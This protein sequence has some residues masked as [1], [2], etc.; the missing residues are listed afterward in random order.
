MTLD[1]SILAVA[2]MA[3]QAYSQG[4]FSVGGMLID[5]NGNLIKKMHNNVV[6]K[7]FI[8]DPTAH[9]ER[10]LIDWYFMEK[11]KSV[12]L[13]EPKD[14]ILITSLDPCCMCTA[15]ILLSGF[16]VVVAAYDEFA[17]IN[18]NKKNNFPSA[19]DQ[20]KKLL[21]KYFSYPKVDGDSIF[22]RNQSGASLPH[23]FQHQSIA[24]TSQALC[25]SI[26]NASA[27]NV[28]YHENHDLQPCYLKNPRDLPDTHPIILELKKYYPQTLEYS[29]ARGNPDEQI[30]P[31][32]L[33]QM[34]IDK[35]QGGKGNAVAFLDYFGNLLLC[36]SGNTNIS[37]IRTAFLEATRTYAHIRFDLYQQFGAEILT[38]L[39]HIKYGTFLFAL[40]LDREIESLL[41]LGA[42]GSSIEGALPDD[43]LCQMQ[44][45]IEQEDPETIR[46]YCAALPPLY[47][48]IIK[49]NPCQVTN[50]NLI[51]ALTQ[52]KTHL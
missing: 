23:T 38:Y 4:T 37:P 22:A 17:G 8:Q 24:N 15:S 10:Q 39:G 32:L 30:V 46:N 14:I 44:Y 5:I 2:E 35:L 27:D 29:C 42:Y 18:Y 50:K 25:F 48:D 19:T 31:Y 34:K 7:N 43:N 40:G 11:H 6:N 26:F 36:C 9:G 1:Q 20:Q 33:E 52:E 21:L 47:S 13:P 3:I 51:K 49:I 41:T 12:P 16:H 28:R 45:V